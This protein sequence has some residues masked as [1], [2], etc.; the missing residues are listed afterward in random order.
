MNII[1][2]LKAELAEKT[3]LLNN[4]DEVYA[5][6][7]EDLKDQRKQFGKSQIQEVEL[8]GKVE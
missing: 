2:D 6:L 1:E 4:K 5:R 8:E 3:N 7:Q